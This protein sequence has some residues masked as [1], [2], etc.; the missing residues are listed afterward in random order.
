MTTDASAGCPLL[1]ADRLTA[2]KQ[3][4]IQQVKA[5]KSDIIACRLYAGQKEFVQRTAPLA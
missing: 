2:K 4:E 3:N 1:N 5:D